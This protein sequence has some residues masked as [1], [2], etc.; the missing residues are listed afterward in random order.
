MVISNPQYNEEGKAK[1]YEEVKQ[2]R[3]EYKKSMGASSMQYWN[4]LFDSMI[5]TYD[6]AYKQYT[7]SFL[8][9]GQDN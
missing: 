5:N 1:F 4:G 8:K 9:E 3:E 2:L 6:K 7:K